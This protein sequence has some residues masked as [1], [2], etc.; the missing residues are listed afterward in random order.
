MP[1][2]ARTIIN[3]IICNHNLLTGIVQLCKST[4]LTFIRLLFRYRIGD[5]YIISPVSLITLRRHF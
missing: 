1:D 3:F 2:C 4:K 5:L